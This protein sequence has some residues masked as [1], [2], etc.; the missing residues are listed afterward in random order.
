M[1]WNL[2]EES[3]RADNAE[4]TVHSLRE[5]GHC[6]Y[7]HFEDFGEEAESRVLAVGG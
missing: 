4:A 5:Q 1:E 6:I 7:S 3:V 2:N